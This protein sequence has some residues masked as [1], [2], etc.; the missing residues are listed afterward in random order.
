MINILIETG[1]LNCKAVDMLIEM[2]HRFGEYSD[3]A[4]TNKGHYQGLV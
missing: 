1:M 2:N 4:P 3:H